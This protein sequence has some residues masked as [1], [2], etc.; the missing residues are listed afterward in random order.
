LTPSVRLSVLEVLLRARTRVYWTKVQF[1]PKALQEP[2]TA[3]R[4]RPL[5]RSHFGTATARLAEAV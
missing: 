5:H 2:P 4:E 1:V 3:T